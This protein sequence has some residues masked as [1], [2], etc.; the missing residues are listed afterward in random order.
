MATEIGDAIR[1]MVAEKSISEELVIS[2]I[3]DILRAAYK[4]KFGTDENAVIEFSEDYTS[5]ELASRRQIVDDDEWYNEVTEIPL[6]EAK[7]IHEECEIGDELL[8][9]V[10]LKEFDRISV[11]SAK[12]RAHQ[13]FRDI[14]KDTLYSEFKAKEGQLIIGYYRRQ[15]PT[16]DIYVDIGSTEGLL[17][18][19][20]QSSRESYQSND[21]IK[22]YVESV[23]KAERG[24]R[25][26]LSRTSSE[27]IRK[28]FEVEVPEIA[29]N[30][31][32][33]IK[34]VRE[35]GYRT[36]VAVASRNDDID[37]VGACVGLKGN[38][39]QTIMSEIEGEKIDILR[40]DPNPINY[41]RNALSP[42]QVK[43]VVVLD[44]NIYH[45][46]AIVE[47]SQLSLAIGKQG[48][49]VRLANKLVDWMIDVKTQAQFD[50]MDIAKEARSRAESI[51]LDEQ[52][53]YGEELVAQ[54]DEEVLIGQEGEVVPE[55]SFVDEDEIALSELP[56]DEILLK[57]LHFH[58]VYSV[59][60]FINLS[61]EDLASF[62]DL[63][64]EE[65][66]AIKDTI[67]EYVDIVED[68]EEAE[69]EYVCPNCGSSITED[70][71]VCPNCG[72]GLVF[73]VE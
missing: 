24:V 4:R 17:P 3:E 58:D 65:I 34:I 60:E 48:L 51:F 35:A 8:I 41:I 29:Q 21:K 66:I 9:P 16:G 71:N 64:E 44:K 39:I 54:N 72:T 70:M 5:V 2:T 20:N 18:R 33:I 6:S 46:V 14:Q 50:E 31:I 45:A 57:K 40:Y 10:D 73:E 56:L 55:E 37:P 15:A 47:D 32:D 68:E 36:K 61:E 26:I 7:E 59:E 69:T 62:S 52:E 12:Q 25:V 22:C 19:R 53:Y 1:S 23:E 49:N 43:D 13:S 63:S 38:R 28:L 42:A 30:Q 11:Q 27:L 67:N